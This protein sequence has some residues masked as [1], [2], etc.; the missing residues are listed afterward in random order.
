MQRAS[1]DREH[2]TFITVSSARAGHA[3]PPEYNATFRHSIF[4]MIV[5]IALTRSGAGMYR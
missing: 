4:V 1:H 5:G 3:T 2:Y